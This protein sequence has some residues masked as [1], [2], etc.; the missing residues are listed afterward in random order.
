M[1]NLNTKLND[2]TLR[3]CILG[4]GYVGLP[5]AEAFSKFFNVKGYDI[6]KKRISEL[7]KKI[8]RNDIKLKKKKFNKKISF[9]TNLKDAQNCDVYI[10]TV[11][12]PIKKNNVP[13]LSLLNK[14]I[15]SLMSINLKNKFIVIESTVYPSLSH[16][17]IKKIES[18]TKLKI[19]KDFYFGYSPERINPGDNLKTIKNIDKIVSCNSKEGLNFLNKLY[20][21]IINKTHVSLSL[22]EAEMAKIIENTQRD[23]NISFIN[24]LSLI[25]QKLNL[26]FENV[27]SLACTKWNFLK[28]TPGLVGGHCISVDPYYLTH[29]LKK[30]NYKPKVILSGRQ[31]NE[32]YPK[33]IYKFIKKKLKRNQTKILIS[34]L[35]YK[36]NC[37]DIR[38]S[39][40]IKLGNL[41]KKNGYDVN[42]YDPHIDLKV[43]DKIK[44]VKNLTNILYDVI[45]I[46]VQHKIF[47]NS[48]GQSIFKRNAKSNSLIYNVKKGSFCN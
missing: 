35:A 24:E 45:I 48:S 5:L 41:F 33:E 11:P 23:I 12:T 13:D 2:K 19:N 29:I 14:A 27:I 18:K 39:K 47:K 36:E 40:S 31:V 43:I 30:N 26:N 9:T 16:D 15:S 17:C 20:K 22:S 32:D 4:L 6:S 8:D 42:F 7:K 44:V 46:C 28:F 3:I 37:N 25:C 10:I 21:K 1:I 34:G 38:N